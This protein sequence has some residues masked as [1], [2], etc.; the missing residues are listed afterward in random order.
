MSILFPNNQV[1]PF[2]IQNSFPLFLLMT[3]GLI[4][5]AA[6]LSSGFK[7]LHVGAHW[8]AVF[9]F[10]LA[11]FSLAVTLRNYYWLAIWDGTTNGLGVLWLFI[12][13]MGI[14]LA[15]IGLVATL[16]R[17]A[18]LTAFIYLLLLPPALLLVT[19]RTQRVDFYQLTDLRAERVNIAIKDYYDQAGYYPDNLQQLTPRHLR[20]LSEP[21]IIFGQDWCYEGEGDQYQF[22]YVYR[23]HWSNPNLVGYAYGASNEEPDLP[24]LC[25]AEIAGL[26]AR[27][28]EY[29]SSQYR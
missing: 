12:P 10:I 2:E 23:E 16:P 27:D 20:S 22:G 25:E 1:Q 17:P 14:F 9:F 21:M 7:L 8:K 28:P 18:K 11:A 19:E 13:I 15:T 4:M 26:R 6:L 29:Y 3:A 24:L 5:V